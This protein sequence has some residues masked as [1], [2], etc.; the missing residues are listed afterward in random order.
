MLSPSCAAPLAGQGSAG[1]P[2][3]G[4]ATILGAVAG[5]VRV[6]LV[7]PVSGTLGLIGP[8]AVNCADLAVQEINEGGGL[9]GRTVELTLVDGG[10]S[11]RD[12]AADVAALVRTGEEHAVVGVHPSD[13][14]VALVGAIGG[15]V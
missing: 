13:V 5:S 10:R 2:R 1:W 14:R 11:P 15:T 12:V 4:N 8:G 3:P 7:V 6:A 9:L